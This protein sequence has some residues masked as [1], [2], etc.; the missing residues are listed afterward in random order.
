MG[1]A[2][3]VH[4][5][6]HIK[7]TCYNKLVGYQSFLCIVINTLGLLVVF[8]DAFIYVTVEDLI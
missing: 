6:W 2:A 1:V 7:Q 8:E 5:C 4:I 3:R